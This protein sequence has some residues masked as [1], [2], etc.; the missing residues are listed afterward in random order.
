MKTSIVSFVIV[1]LAI[2]LSLAVVHA[3]EN[4]I[5]KELVTKGVPLSNGKTIILPQPVMADG[6]DEANQQKVLTSLTDAQHLDSFLKGGLNDW[7]ELKKTSTPGA[8]AD[9]SIGRQVDLY[10]VAQGK[11]DTAT[12][13]NFMKKVLNQNDPKAKGKADYFTD[14]ELKSRKLTVTN[15]ATVK[16][17]YAHAFNKILGKVEVSG[18]GRGIRTIDPESMLVAD[19]LDPRFANDPDYPNQWQSIKIVAG[20]PALGKSEKYSG[21][22]S[23]IKV[24]KLKGA[25]DRVFV[26]YHL[27]FDEP[28]GW[29]N[30]QANLMSHLD[31]VYKVDVRKFRREMQ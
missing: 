25:E 4:V 27:I 13:P 30:G 18:A 31:D 23:Y 28:H 19:K 15:T 21:L 29:F 14:A 16:E 1:S 8:K 20:A 26:E 10:Y 7:Y 11:L 24:T 12:N 17:K 5:F 2:V 3:D 9:D 6:L 22:G